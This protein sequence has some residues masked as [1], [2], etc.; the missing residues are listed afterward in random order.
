MK[1]GWRRASVAGATALAATVGMAAPVVAQSQGNG[2]LF[3]VPT[4]SFALRVGYARPNAGSDVYSDLISQLTLGRS[5]FGAFDVAGDLAFRV[6]P[7]LDAVFGLGYSGSRARSEYRDWVDQNNLPIE[8][9]TTLQR[10]PL[11]ASLKWY[12]VP[13]G[14]SIGRFAW[15]P[16]KY[17]PYVGLGGGAMWYYL[18]QWGAFINFADSTLPVY[19]D[20]LRSTAWALM[21]H[22]FAGLDVSLSPRFVL[23][24]EARYTYAKAPLGADFQ[25]Y[26]RIDLSG[27][28][29]TA[30][31]AVRF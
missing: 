27:L 22:A 2:F 3:R 28:S 23:T 7:R 30:G 1:I 10:V 16:R 31:L 26:H 12:L 4:G 29:L 17:A 21:G 15:L 18:H 25:L 6:A 19:N 20:D 5:D 9:Q 11:T 8:Q 14:R 13:R 24:G